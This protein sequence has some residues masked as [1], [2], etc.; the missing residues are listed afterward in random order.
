MSKFTY[1]SLAE[2]DI[3]TLADAAL[4]DWMETYTGFIPEA[5]IEEF[6]NEAYHPDRIK[7]MVPKVAEGKMGFWLAEDAEGVQGWLQVSDFG[8]GMEIGRSGFRDEETVQGLLGVAET[9]LKSKGA[10][11]Y[12]SYVDRDDSDYKMRLELNGFSHVAK[13]D[14]GE[15]RYL[16]KRLD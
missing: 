1:R 5:D 13:K 4:A 6:V 15:D 11:K 16:E 8:A 3:D 12:F 14:D 9:F 2:S 10:K 7:E